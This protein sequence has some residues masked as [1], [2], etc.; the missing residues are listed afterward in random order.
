ME[1]LVNRTTRTA[2]ST[3]SQF[4]IVGGTFKCFSLEPTDRGLTSEMPLGE[5]L[6]K[7]VAGETAMPTGRYEMDWYYSPDH[8][9]WLP[10]ILNVPGFEDDEIHIGNTA[11]DTRGCLV[12]GTEAASD[13]VL[14]SKVAINEFYPLFKAA[15]AKEKVFITIK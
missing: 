1:L 13:D 11:K 10:R 9:I 12:L 5:I 15:I 4:S 3:I 14:N 6:A 2:Q 8:G 7:K